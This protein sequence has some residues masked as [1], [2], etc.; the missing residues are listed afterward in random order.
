MGCGG[1]PMNEPV[2]IGFVGL[3]IISET[4]LAVLADLPEAELAFTVD[5]RTGPA[6]FRDATP[7]HY[8][9]LAD[10]LKEHDADLIVIATPTSTHADLATEALTST[11]ARVL[12]EKPLV[13]NL[14][15]LDQFTSLA[16]ELDL[17]QRLLVAHHFAFS[18]EVRWAADLIE[19]HPDWGPMTEITSAFYDP[20]ILRGQ[21]AFDSYGS[22]WTDSGINQLSMLTR[23]V[24]LDQL[25]SRQE[26]DNGAAAWATA[27]Y[28]S[29]GATGLARLRTSWL[30]GSSSK[31][32]T[33]RLAE[34]DIEIWLDHTAMT[35][36][37]ARGDQL[38]ATHDNDGQTP[39]K[40]AHYRPLYEP[41]LADASET[42]LTLD[43]ARIVTRLLYVRPERALSITKNDGPRHW[44]QR[45]KP[46]SE[47]PASGQREPR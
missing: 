45:F 28:R 43:A 31:R 12:V 33:L 3:G 19:A 2:R 4:H 42:A 26:T 38:L 46:T 27:H 15:A 47:R 11:S 29:R 21:E 39:R 7:P 14:D 40:V 5:P 22:S 16:G 1:L 32:T 30:T 41:I 25:T 37:A 23:F 36:F 9:D 44:G 18:P 20:Y 35:G 17:D 8:R 6:T 13:H 34:A 10:A 24:D